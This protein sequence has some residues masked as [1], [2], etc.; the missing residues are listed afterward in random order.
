MDVCPTKA[1]RWGV[2]GEG[3]G[4]VGLP[5]VALGWV[6]GMGVDKR[7]VWAGASLALWSGGGALSPAALQR[8]VVNHGLGDQGMVSFGWHDAM[9]YCSR[10]QLA[11]PTGRSPSAAFPLDPF[12]P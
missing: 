6:D 5:T 2:D 4:A 12:P 3:G 9:V 11:A 10:L 1:L 8:S 7:E